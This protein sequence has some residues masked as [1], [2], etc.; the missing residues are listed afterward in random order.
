MCSFSDLITHTHT[1]SMTQYTQFLHDKRSHGG[2][3]VTQAF[4][5]STQEPGGSE[6][7]ASLF[8]RTSSRTA[9]TTHRNPGLKKKN[10]IQNALISNSGKQNDLIPPR[11]FLH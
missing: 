11:T 5:P 6:F 8:Y 9:K 1:P 3:G 7:N 2:A 10:M 4:N